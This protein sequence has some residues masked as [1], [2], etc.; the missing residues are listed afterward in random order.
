M[1]DMKE[2]EM[3]GMEEEE[4]SEEA[5]IKKGVEMLLISI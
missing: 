5:D 4:T 1:S 2:I 3:C